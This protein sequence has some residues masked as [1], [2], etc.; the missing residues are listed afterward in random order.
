MLS[1]AYVASHQDACTCIGIGQVVTPRAM[2][3]SQVAALLVVRGEGRPPSYRPHPY[4]GSTSK[5]EW[6]TEWYTWC[7]TPRTKR[8]PSPL[9][10][11]GRGGGWE[12][13]RTVFQYR[14][15]L[16]GLL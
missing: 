14:L 5:S 2:V 16:L 4:G 13:V 9:S 7:W 12:K 15:R 8:V 11:D 6:G 3:R 10:G 1:T